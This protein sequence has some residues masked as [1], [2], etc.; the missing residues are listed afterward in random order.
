MYE[1]NSRRVNSSS[2]VKANESALSI[3]TDL[4]RDPVYMS[5]QVIPSRAFAQA[6][7]VLGA[8][9]KIQRPAKKDHS[10]YQ[11]WVSQEY[12]RIFQERSPDF[13]AEQAVLVARRK[14]LNEK[15]D[16]LNLRLHSL[17]S[18]VN[19]KKKAYFDWLFENDRN[20]WIVLD[21][22]VSVQK[23]GTFFEAF[24]GDESIYARVFLPHSALDSTEK[25]SLGTTNIDFSLLLEREFDR[26][27]SYRP[28]SLTVG[29]KSVD[30]KTEAALVEEEKIPL[31][32]TWV[33]GLVEVQSVLAL[34]PT[35]FEMSSDALSEIIARL[36]SEKEKSGPRSLK[37]L[38]KPNQPIRIEIEPWGEVFAD[39][40]CNFNGDNEATVRIWGRRRLAVLK[41]ILVGTSRVKVHFLG[42]GMP[43]FWT[44]I[45]DG[46]ELT[47]G[48]SGWTSNDWASKAK[49]SS[50]I[51][52]AN[53][54]EEHIPLALE[55]IVKNGSITTSE[56]AK[57]LSVSVG[58][59]SVLLQKLC[60]QGK[61]MF[62]PDRNLYRWR[63]LFPTL[64]L[65][66]DDDSSREMRGALAN[67]S[68]FKLKKTLDDVK[69]GVRYLSGT[70]TYGSET[71]KPL[72]E[73]DLDNRPKYA[74]CSCSFYN[75]NKLRQGPCRHMITLLLVGD[76]Q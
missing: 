68:L 60:L 65:Y 31:P 41:D 26:V 23:D 52:T 5:G 73:L 12:L 51:P 2:A 9:V 70:I 46:V 57:N 35:T 50:F 29:L 55:A 62:D 58:E 24:S 76:A 16:N 34:A 54:K 17:Q 33:R 6:M 42:S 30:F 75:F 7:L 8:V 28:M 40:W 11:A 43:S 38:L 21:P 49:F 15:R 13:L 14:E 67:L 71:F 10:A 27:R 32:E 61:A 64:D 22:I 36:Q 66:V 69:D 45:K 53:V 25:P 74:Q 19:S 63:D 20:A 72:L 56:L 59:A 39:D 48:L 4:N 44:V 1:R 18:F 47:I 3:G 37:F